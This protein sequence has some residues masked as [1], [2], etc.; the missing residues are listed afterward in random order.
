[1]GVGLG[2][3]NLG[4][5]TIRVFG[6]CLGFRGRWGGGGGGVGDDFFLCIILFLVFLSC[7]GGR[8]G[9]CFLTGELSGSWGAFRGF[10]EIC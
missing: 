2:F 7:W 10:V 4:L 6:C 5:V 1:M 9:L 8:G 3:L